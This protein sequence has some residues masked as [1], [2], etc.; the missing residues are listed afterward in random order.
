M[1]QFELFVGKPLDDDLAV[2]VMISLCVKALHCRLELAVMPRETTM[3]WR[4]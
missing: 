3:S 4:N 2:I 1:N